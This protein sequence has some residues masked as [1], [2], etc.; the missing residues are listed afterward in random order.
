VI[1]GSFEVDVVETVATQPFLVRA[2][3]GCPTEVH[4]PLSQ[5]QF[6]QP[7]SHPH[8]IGTGIFAGPHQIAHRLD[9]TL[10]YPHFGDLA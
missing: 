1:E 7:M 2:R 10:R 8:Q 4:D 3:P 6:R 5:K 9:L